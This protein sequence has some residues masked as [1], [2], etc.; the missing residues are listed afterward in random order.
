MGLKTP[1]RRDFEMKSCFKEDHLLKYLFSELTSGWD[2][3]EDP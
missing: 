1:D 3:G 2:F